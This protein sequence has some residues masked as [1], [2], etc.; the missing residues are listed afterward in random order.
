MRSVSD[1]RCTESQ[2]TLF[3]FSNFFE[4]RDIYETM[5]TNLL[6][7]GRPQMTISACALHAG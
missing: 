6:E 3:V 7:P 5:W 2:N 4:N 1:K